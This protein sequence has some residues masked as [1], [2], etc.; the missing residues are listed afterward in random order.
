M[1]GQALRPVLQPGLLHQPA[2]LPVPV[3]GLAPRHVLLIHRLPPDSPIHQLRRVKPAHQHVHQAHTAAA[4][5][6]VEVTAAEEAVAVA[7]AIAEEAVAAAVEAAEDKGYSSI[8][9]D[10]AISRVQ[11]YFPFLFAKKLK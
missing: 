3:R 4:D 1:P 8:G 10:V 9:W 5:A 11:T 6:V 2:H 7:A